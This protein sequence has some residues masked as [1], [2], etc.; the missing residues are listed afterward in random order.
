MSH[1]KLSVERSPAGAM[2]VKLTNC[3]TV[4]RER[5][6]HFTPRQVE[7]LTEAFLAAGAYLEEGELPSW[8]IED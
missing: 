7:S 8:D 1:F 3:Y 5:T 6:W 4:D 2:G